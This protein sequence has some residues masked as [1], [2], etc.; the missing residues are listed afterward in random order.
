MSLEIHRSNVNFL[1]SSYFC[2]SYKFF[3]IL[4][5]FKIYECLFLFF[6]PLHKD[7]KVYILRVVNRLNG[8]TI[9]L[10]LLKAMRKKE[11]NK[12]CLLLINQN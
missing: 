4:Y 9:V 10:Y 11:I 3:H 6:F 1:Q 7:A 8:I 5:L 12:T 2:C